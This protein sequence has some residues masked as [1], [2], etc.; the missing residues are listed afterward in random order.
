MKKLILVLVLTLNLG[1]TKDKEPYNDGLPYFKFLPQDADKIVNSMEVGKIIIYK[2][3]DNIELKFKVIKNTVEKKL[4]SRGT[5]V[6]GSYKYFYYDEQRIQFGGINDLPNQ[7][8]AEYSSFFISVRRFPK[9]FTTNPTFISSDSQVITNVGLRPFDN[10]DVGFLNYT[11]PITNLTINS[12]IY[13]KVRKIMIL[14]NQYPNPNSTLKGVTFIY[15]D[16]N[17]GLV[18]FDDVE[19]KMWRLQN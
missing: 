8:Y 3:Q 6:V 1:C 14:V 15:F 2:N 10:S 11:E 12:T 13:N 4:E 16:Q 19:N 7:H 18:G 17:K 9:V 5:F